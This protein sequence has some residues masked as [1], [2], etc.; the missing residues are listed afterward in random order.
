[1][2]IFNRSASSWLKVVPWGLRNLLNW[3]KTE[4]NNPELYITENG[5]SDN[6]GTLQD[7]KRIYFYENY[8][9]NVLKG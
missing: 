8:I 3:I 2:V 9:N 6:S 4:Y 5:V 7:D 1:M